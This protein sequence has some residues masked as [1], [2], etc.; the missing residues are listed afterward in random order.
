MK[1]GSRQPVFPSIQNHFQD[2][3]VLNSKCS[4]ELKT[5][6]RQVTLGIRFMLVASH[7]QSNVHI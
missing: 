6:R 1:S 2:D 4:P 3:D 5:T 7:Y